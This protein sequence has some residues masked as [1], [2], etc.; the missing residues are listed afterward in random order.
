MPAPVSIDAYLKTTLPDRRAALERVRRSI[1]RLVPGVE[2]CISYSMP[3]FRKDGSVI[4]GFIATKAG[5]SYLP[6]SGTTLATLAADLT[7]YSQTKSSLH[8]DPAKGIPDS[9]LRKLLRIRRAEVAAALE[10]KAAKKGS[11]RKTASP[12]AKKV[13]RPA[14]QRRVTKA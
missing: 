4:A 13:P 7:G 12:V 5:C 11:S 9:L 2:E 14:P 1:H 8:F 3:A 6:F 10:A